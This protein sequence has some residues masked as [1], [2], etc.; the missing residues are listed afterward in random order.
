MRRIAAIDGLRAVAVLSVLL[1]H[2]GFALLPGGL[3]GVDIFFVISGFVVSR[4]ILADRGDRRRAILAGFYARRLRRIAAALIVVLVLTTLAYCLFVPSAWL[5]DTV[6]RTGLSAF[7]GFSNVV[8]GLNGDTYFSPTATLN[9]FTHTWSLGVEEQFYLLLPAILILSGVTSP[10]GERR[11]ATLA[12]G[13]LAALSLVACSLLAPD[14]QRLVFYSIATRFWELGIGVLLCLT[15][16]R[17]AQAVLR[18]PLLLQNLVA[19]AGAAAILFVLCS[20]PGPL[21]PFPQ[22]IVADLGAAVLIAIVVTRPSG[23]T[24]R[25]LAIG[26][27]RMI[28]LASYSIYLWHW[29][30]IVI[31]RW[32][33][34]LDEMSYRL[35]A[36]AASLLLGFLSYHWVEQPT[37]RSAIL[38]DGFPGRHIALH[39]LLLAGGALI[40]L[41]LLWAKNQISLSRTADIATWYSSKGSHHVGPPPLHAVRYAQTKTKGGVVR[42]FAPERPIGRTVFVIGDSHSLPYLPAFRRLAEDTGITV[43]A[44]FVPHCSFL[45][46][47]VAMRTIEGCNLDFYRAALAEIAATGH[48]GDILFLPNLRVPRL[49]DQWGPVQ[50]WVSD[51]AQRRAATAEAVSLLRPVSVQ[52][53]TILFESPM[54]V[55]KSV[56]FRCSDW[57]N[58]MNP[59]C[60]AGFEVPRADMDAMR[61]E[62]LAQMQAIAD[63]LGNVRVWNA[64]DVLCPGR[65]CSAFHGEQP[66]FLDGDHLSGYGQSFL[67]PSL[68]H[69]V[70]QGTPRASQTR[71]D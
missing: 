70:L 19:L 13:V 48:R 3:A 54:P 62:P 7:A 59:T 57:F 15:E 27:I 23:A 29:P 51:P 4:S 65:R 66:L 44:Y 55:F 24:T 20:V 45:P 42:T 67:Y 28:G 10:K 11:V 1:Y 8:L 68:K 38:K 56:P 39:L 53:I 43:R 21:F 18:L 33:V 35:C 34:G 32:T 46:L 17:W 50:P 36:V 9:P 63:A 5:S 69:A 25:L 6:Q 14:H 41:G 30:L 22:A 58:R 60:A 16:A 37:Q 49:V 47:N 26:P 12:V 64:F 71:T 40:S 2:A 31:M 52:G 61:T